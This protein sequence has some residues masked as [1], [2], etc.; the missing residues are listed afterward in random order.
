M[1]KFGT[2][3]NLQ[4]LVIKSHFEPKAILRNNTR[5]FYNHDENELHESYN[6]L[7]F[8]NLIYI[9]QQ[10]LIFY[11]QFNSNKGVAPAFQLL[12]IEEPE[13]H[14]HAQMQYIFII[15]IKEFI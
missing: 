5:L 13:S 1:Q 2:N 3:T 15:N 7:G 4:Q 10:F 11:K 8:S 12:F 14:L 6:G 9:V